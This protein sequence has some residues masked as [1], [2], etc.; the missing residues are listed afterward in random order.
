MRDLFEEFDANC[1]SCHVDQ[2]LGDPPLQLTADTF[3]KDIDMRSVMSMRAETD[4]MPPDGYNGMPWSERDKTGSDAIVELAAK[5]EAFIAQGRPTTFSA[6]IV[7]ESKTDDKTPKTSYLLSP[8]VGMQMTNLGNCVPDKQMVAKDVDKIDALDKMFESAAALPDRLDQ[9]D[10]V[11]LD[12]KELAKSGVI[13]Y[14]PGYT[15]WA[16]NA[17]KLRMVRVPRGQ[18]IKFDKDKQEFSMPANTRFY[19]TFMKT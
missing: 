10:L 16:D 18:S 19:K 5:I 4:Y 3:A 6:P 9:T 2:A 14:A 12:S 11:T 15:L 13:A 17:K 7:G 1:G 8:A